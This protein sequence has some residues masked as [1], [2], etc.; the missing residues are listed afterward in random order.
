MLGVG[1]V[2]FRIIVLLR[3]RRG[4]RRSFVRNVRRSSGGVTLV[5]RVEISAG[6]I[7]KGIKRVVI[8]KRN[9]IAARNGRSITGRLFK[10]VVKVIIKTRASVREVALG[11]ANDLSGG[12][13]GRTADA[14]A[15]LLIRLISGG[16]IVRHN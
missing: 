10:A 16:V 7:G 4:R 9:I 5:R 8:N 14:N 2:I 15:R 12:R 6:I 1:D 11:S 3:K 13:R